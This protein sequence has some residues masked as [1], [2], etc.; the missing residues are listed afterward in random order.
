MSQAIALT[1]G[2]RWINSL[3]KSTAKLPYGLVSVM[4]AVAAFGAYTSMYAFRKAFSAGSFTGSEFWHVDYKAWL[5]IAQVLGYTLSKFYGI[6]FIAEIKALSRGKSILLL[7]G[8]SWLALLAFA[9][10]PAPY[11]IVFLFINGFPLGMIWGLVFGYLEG[12]KATE[13][14]A[15]VLSTSLIFASGFVKTVGRTLIT[16][17]NVSE[18]NMPFLTGAIFVIPLL[19][20]VLMLEVMP[21]PTE[22]DKQSRTERVAMSATERKAF[23]ARFFPGI[24]LTVIVYVLLTVMRDI[25]DNFEVE[26]WAGL[27]NNSNTIYTNIDSVI[28]IAILAAMSLLILVKNNLKAFGIIHVFIIC[29]CL[30]AGISTLLFQAGSISPVTWMTLAGLGLYAGYVPY[31]AI[32]FERMIASYNYKSNVGFIMYVADAIGYLGSISVLLVKELG[33]WDVSWATFFKNGL[34]TMSVIGA[35]AGSLSLIYFLQS[36]G[37]AVRKIKH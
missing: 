2:P 5:V 26:I 25:R 17:Y 13:F 32:F 3:K 12:R 37:K 10:V 1:Q 35:V 24:V 4:A 19:L 23:L 27:G 16:N 22:Q 11:N 6:K 31:N 7:I 30:M 18:Y 28:S 36:A 15:A 29:G 20:F 33:D 9:F 8:I 34:L 14:M 21:P